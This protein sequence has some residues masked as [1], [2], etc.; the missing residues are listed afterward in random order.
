MATLEGVARQ[1]SLIRMKIPPPEP[2][3]LKSKDWHAILSVIRS[4]L[5]A[6]PDA[7]QATEAVI[8]SF[9]SPM[10]R[11]AVHYQLTRALD[12]FM[13]ARIDLAEA[14]TGIHIE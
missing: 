14:L 13:D 7:L 2:D 8:A 10:R 1:L 11:E 6:Y 12:P 5:V 3:Y 9:A 4:V